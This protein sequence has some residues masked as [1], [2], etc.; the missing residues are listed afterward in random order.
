[1]RNAVVSCFVGSLLACAGAN[2]QSLF[3]NLPQPAVQGVVPVDNTA[4]DELATY[5]MI[6][7]KPPR[8][9]NYNIHDLVT[10]IVEE[11]STQSADQ[12][13]KTDKTYNNTTDLNALVDAWQLLQ[14]QLRPGSLSNEKLLD[15]SNKQKFDGKGTY[16]RNDKLQLKIQAEIIDVKPNGTLV[17]EA[18]KTIDKNG[19]TQVTVLSGH[20]RREDITNANTILS[21][22]L[23]DL[24]IVTK[25]EGQVDKAGK[26]GFIPRALE[27]LFAF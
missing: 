2:A 8:P 25:S 19:E 4:L 16:T 15:I 22:Q 3:R 17:L 9:R 13:L 11:T 20:V 21:S 12:Q 14:L 5:S 23:A 10:I 26:K 6:A 24:T 27:T 1:M 18:R 7:V